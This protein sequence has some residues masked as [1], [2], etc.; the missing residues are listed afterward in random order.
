[1][2]SRPGSEVATWSTF[3]GQKR[4]RDIGDS[5]G[6]RDMDFGVATWKSYCGQ[7]RGRDMNLMSRNGLASRRS[8]PRNDVATWVGLFEVATWT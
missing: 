2:R 6:G 4:R 5:V 8:R 1:M 3:V 7:E